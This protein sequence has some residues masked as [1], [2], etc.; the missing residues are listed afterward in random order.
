MRL[1]YRTAYNLVGIQLALHGI[2][3]EGQERMIMKGGVLIVA[4]HVSFMDPTTVGWA[5]R[6]ELF[7]L[8]RKTLFKPPIMDWLLPWC[9]VLPIDRDG[10]ESSSLRQIIHLLKNGGPLLLFPE[11]TRSPDGNLQKAYPGA[12]FIAVKAGV[13]IVP[14]RLFGT[15]ESF[16]RHKKL[17]SFKPIRVVIGEP[18]QPRLPEGKRDKHIYGTV[19]DEMMEKI[20]QLH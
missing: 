5:V 12:G 6:R 7:Y 15:Y 18:Y 9:N 13:P 20:R 8:A 2:K 3:V 16:P 14:V 11:G 1:F 4:N 10:G 19:A 17:P